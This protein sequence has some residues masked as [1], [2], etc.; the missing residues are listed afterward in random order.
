MATLVCEVGRSNRAMLRQHM[1]TSTVW[2]GGPGVVGTGHQRNARFLN[3]AGSAANVFTVLAT[4]G[5][6]GPGDRISPANVDPSILRPHPVQIRGNALAFAGSLYSPHCAPAAVPCLSPSIR[7]VFPVR[8]TAASA[9]CRLAHRE[10]AR[11]FRRPCLRGPRA[12]RPR[13]ARWGG[14]RVRDRARSAAVPAVGSVVAASVGDTC[15]M[16]T[17]ALSRASRRTVLTY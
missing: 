2:S 10:S 11:R 1:E 17:V 5:L 15:S 9:P 7:E 12:G 6:A 3:P 8:A 13:V 4:S 14:G 16:S